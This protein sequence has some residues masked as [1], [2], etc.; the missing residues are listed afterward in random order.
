MLALHRGHFLIFTVHHGTNLVA[1]H[2]TFDA[3]LKLIIMRD[4]ELL[5]KSL[6]GVNGKEC[7]D[8]DIIDSILSK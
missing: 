7:L 6:T 2:Q 4:E 1:S 5:G 3:L 8:K